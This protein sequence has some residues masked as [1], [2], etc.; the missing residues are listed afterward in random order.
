MKKERF[1]EAFVKKRILL[2][3][4]EVTR[5]KANDLRNWLMFL[6]S[7]SKKEIKL[8]IDSPGGEV[9]AALLLHDAI[10]LSASP[11]TCIINGECSSSGVVILQAAKKR[12]MTK[13]SFIYLHPISTSFE[14]QKIIANGKIEEKFTNKLR[15]VKERQRFIHD[16]IIKKTG[17]TLEEIKA[18]EEKI[19]LAQEAKEF[20]LVDEVIEKYKI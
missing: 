3:I 10:L 11:V 2:L 17:R 1:D 9:V 14:K 4:G 8:I 5:E 18:K 16:I 19:I 6:N 20:G 15:S 12:L 7:K 13:H